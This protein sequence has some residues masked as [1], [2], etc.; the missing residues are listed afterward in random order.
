MER[1][2]K[3]KVEREALPSLKIFRRSDRRFPTK[4][5]GKSFLATRASSRDWKRG[6]LT[7]L[8]R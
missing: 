7:N 6:V 1:G 8:E 3:K 4:Q 5:E 2:E